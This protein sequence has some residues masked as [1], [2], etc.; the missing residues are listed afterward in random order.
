MNRRISS[1]PQSSSG[2][3]S[4]P[5]PHTPACPLEDC[6]HDG[7][8]REVHGK[9]P[10]SS[11]GVSKGALARKSTVSAGRGQVR[12]CDVRFSPLGDQL[13]QPATPD[14]SIPRSA[15]LFG[16]YRSQAATHCTDALVDDRLIEEDR[17]AIEEEH[18]PCE[19]RNARA[20][21]RRPVLVRDAL[22]PTRRTLQ[23]P[24]RQVL[25]RSDP[26]WRAHPS[27]A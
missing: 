8:E 24:A 26:A 12:G 15:M 17:V 23:A 16:A 1:F 19:R 5:P 7:W 11:G 20:G 9:E 3:P 18:A 14:P 25:E 10:P 4:C 27:S 13:Q 2:N 22:C 6:G 21:S